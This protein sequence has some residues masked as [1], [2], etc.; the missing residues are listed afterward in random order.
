M[1]LYKLFLVFFSCFFLINSFSLELRPNS[2]SFIDATIVLESSGRIV[3]EITENDSLIVKALSFNDFDS[4]KII[5]LSEKLFINGKEFNAVPEFI[6]GSRY[7]VFKINNLFEF[8]KNPV[9][10]I[11]IT[12]RVQSTSE[13]ELKPRKNASAFVDEF[14]D[15]LKPT[16]LIESNDPELVSKAKIEFRNGASIE[17]VREISDW[18]SNNLDY[19]YSFYSVVN[20]AKKTYELRKGV[21]DEFAN[22][23]AAFTRI[24][25][26]PTK[27]VSGVSFDGKEFGN[28]GWL[29]V[30][31]R[32][33][34]WLP[35]DSTYGEV[36]FVDAAH[37]VLSKGLDA[38][39]FSS[40]ESTISSVNNLQLELNLL[41]P[42]VKINELK[43]FSN[44]VDLNIV[45]PEKLGLNQK[46]LIT[47]LIKSNLKHSL[48][49]PIQLFVHPEFLIEK[50][51]K[52]VLLEPNKQVKVNW[53]VVSP[54]KGVKGKYF[55]YGGAI[56]SPDLN[57]EFSLIV[58]PNKSKNKL[59]GEEIS[60]IDV[61]PVKKNT[62]LIVLFKLK[63]NSSI[64]KQVKT[65]LEFNEQK[66]GEEKIVLKENELKQVQLKIPDF[67]HGS[68]KLVVDSNN[69][70]ELEI[71]VPLKQ[72]PVVLTNSL[73][74]ND[75]EN[76]TIDS[77]VE[78]DF[79]TKLIELIIGFFKGL[80]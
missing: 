25:G 9:F 68:L 76:N 60:L 58:F 43:K 31:I 34:G 48:I 64:V 75:F 29:E 19:D 47:A 28:H 6:N 24:K 73:D 20:S 13:I 15:Y 74:L 7:A 79:L 30:F 11:I 78:K 77:V 52:L 80:F 57:K 39:E 63:N 62:D 46:F 45:F 40:I 53:V 56:H 72:E 36:G 42:K 3:G 61:S 18:V 2:I 14:K 67:S 70:K 17:T 44:L 37:F 21:C 12:A 65:W 23:T 5:D 49:Y 50:S 33:I 1:N 35:V 51:K 22:L 26:I 10:K 8:R 16:K 41:E 59:I 71:F 32:G 27:Y 54:R 4:Q 55:S 66:F 38:S 69:L